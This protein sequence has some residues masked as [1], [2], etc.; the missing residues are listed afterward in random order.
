MEVWKD[1]MELVRC[2][3]GPRLTPEQ[4]MNFFVTQLVLHRQYDAA[5]QLFLMTSSS[6][7]ENSTTSSTSI[8]TNSITSTKTFELVLPFKK[9]SMLV[10]LV[11]VQILHM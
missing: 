4:V 10:L 7:T 6:S 9:I 8:T 3:F 11:L 5:K 1:I 2:I